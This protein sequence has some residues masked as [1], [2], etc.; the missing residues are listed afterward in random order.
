MTKN[1]F[2]S[3]LDYRLK[4]LP[5][6]ERQNAM[7]Y[8]IEYFDDAGVE[9]EQKV[10]MELGSPQAVASQILSD[11]AIKGLDAKQTGVKKGASSIWLV[12][13]AIFAAPIALPLAIAFAAILL[14]VFAVLFSLVA[15]GG[16]IVIAGVTCFIASFMVVFQSVPTTMFFGGCGLLLVGLGTL[17]LLGM[18]GACKG[19]FALT[20]KIF[21]SIS[22]KRR[23]KNEDYPPNFEPSFTPENYPQN[24]TTST[25]VPTTSVVQSVPASAIVPQ[26]PQNK[27]EGVVL[28]D[29]KKN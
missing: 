5:W 28:H 2:L 24:N 13:L 12:V 7:H 22:K 8:Y 26:A 20:S 29:E 1:D 23:N 9:N 15:A 19:A 27:V 6:E 25:D 17:M 21:K 10:I 11:Y 3:G 4:Q 14:S 16:A 18:I